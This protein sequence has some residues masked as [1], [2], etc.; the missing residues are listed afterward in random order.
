MMRH[1]MRNIRF[2]VL[3]L[4]AAQS[5]FTQVIE[6]RNQP[7]EVVTSIYGVG[8]SM[9]SASGFGLSF[10]HHLPGSFSYQIVGGVI[11]ADKS[12]L[13]NIGGEM[14]ID[15]VRT[16][17]TR[18]FGAAALGYFYK[19]ENGNDL[20]SPF[21]AGAGVGLEY[22]QFRSIAIGGEILFTFFNDGDILPLPQVSI[23]YYFF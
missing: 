5:S 13:G 16:P 8:I 4:L 10:R 23:H 18:F 6:P 17:R 20:S 1:I 2:L 11:K 7:D 9:G 15:F 22:Q 3:F 14:Q 19:G 12:T 21:R